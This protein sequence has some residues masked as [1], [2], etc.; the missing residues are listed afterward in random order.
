MNRQRIIP[1]LLVIIVFSVGWLWA[2]NPPLSDQSEECISC[3]EQIHP[4]IVSQW[5][6]SR[7]AMVT[8]A[9]GLAK[10]KLQRRIS[11]KNIPDSLKQTAVGCF[12]CHGI[13]PDK[14]K[15]TFE[16]NGYRIHVVVTPNDCA[17][18]H[19][20]EVKEYSQN[21]MAHA[22]DNLMKNSVYQQL[23][24]SVIGQTSEKNGSLQFAEPTQKT[25]ADA[26]LY[27][28]GTKVKVKG[29]VTRETDFGEMDFPVLEGWPNQGVG[30]INPDGSMGSC[31]SCHSRHDFSIAMARKPSTCAE[32]HKGPDVPAYKVYQVSKHG[33]IY[34][35][36]HEHWNFE[37][38]PWTV[39]K[40]FTAPTCATCHVSLIINS[41]STVIA[42]RTHRFNDRLGWRL[43]GA[44]Y[45]HAHPKSP[46]LSIIHNKAGLPLATE[47]DGTPVKSFLISPEEQQKR[48]QRMEAVC[49]TCH[50]SNWVDN[51]FARLAN[52]IKETNANT[53]HA[54]EI[55][56]KIWKA[57][58]A[59]PTN[60]FDE[61]IERE[62]TSL[63]LFYNNSTR[64]TSAMGGGGDY[65]V[66]ANGRY[67]ASQNLMRLHDWLKWHLK[68]VKKHK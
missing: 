63:W 6:Q 19:S 60:M 42:E 55:M 20:K 35:A 59:D 1:Q 31:T 11:S 16:H 2:D 66:F 57:G 45:A 23:I 3:H 9:Q 61:A 54:T 40:D 28:H 68:N 39:G 51:H 44:P 65:G 38:V 14:H 56:Q 46:D 29:K 22:Y 4:G 58:L 8:P 67:Q 43:F 25:S 10:P 50:S 53:R 37:A 64:F 21:L 41:D 26:C 13:N 5:Q 36:Q 30:R 52:T 15:D 32:C 24:H 27:C 7:H 48:E 33:N 34:T 47:L 18:C 62:W 12:E 49:L 17:T